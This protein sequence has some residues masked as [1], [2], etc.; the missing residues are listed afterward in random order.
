MELQQVN[1][2]TLK[3]VTDKVSASDDVILGK[4][5]SIFV[6]GARRPLAIQRRDLGRGE[7][8][9]RRVCFQVLAEQAIAASFAVG[10][11][12]IK[13]CAAEVSGKLKSFSR[14]LVVRITP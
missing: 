6:C 11:G 2:V 12:S 7:E 4:H 8:S 14:L 13:E 5:V 1:G 9:F 10:P 3:G